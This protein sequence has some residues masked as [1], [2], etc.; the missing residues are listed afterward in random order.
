MARISMNGYKML[1]KRAL[2]SRVA[3]NCAKR[4]SFNFGRSQASL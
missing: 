2:E 3:T 1:P 4:L